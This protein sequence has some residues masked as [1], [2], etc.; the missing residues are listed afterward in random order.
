MSCSS[1]QPLT[2]KTFVYCAAC[3]AAKHRP[4]RRDIIRHPP[5]N[6]LITAYL[7]PIYGSKPR[8]DR[9]MTATSTYCY[10][11]IKLVHL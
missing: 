5:Y 9:D 11:K 10:T 1:A 3:Y 7:R 2:L 8:R 6:G 4:L